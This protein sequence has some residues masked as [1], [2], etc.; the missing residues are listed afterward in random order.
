MLFGQVGV[1]TAVVDWG[2]NC[3]N[4]TSAVGPFAIEAGF[5]APVEPVTR[6]RI[7]SE[8]TGS[9]VVAHVPVECGRVQ[10]EGN[11]EIPGVPGRAAR[12]IRRA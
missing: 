2:G 10:T 11:Y 1:R 9:R 6:V 5:V 7:L 8:N 12:M 3:G 4:L